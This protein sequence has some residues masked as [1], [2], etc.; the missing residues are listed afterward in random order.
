MRSLVWMIW[1][2]RFDRSTTS[3]SMIPIVPD[4][5]RGEVQRGRRAEPARADQ[6]RLRA[7]QLRLALGADLGD[8]QVA[9]VA[10]LLGLGQLRRRRPVE[11]VR[12]PGLEAARHRRDVG[13][14]HVRERLRGE[15]AADAAGAVQDDGRVAVRDGGLDLLLEVALRDVGGAGDVALVPLGRLA[16]VDHRD[17]PALAERVGLGGRHLADAASSL[18]EKLGVG[19]RHG[20]G[21]APVGRRAAD[22][23]AGRGSGRVRRGMR[24][25]QAG[26]RRD[27]RGRCEPAQAGRRHAQR[28][29]TPSPPRRAAWRRRPRG[30][31]GGSRS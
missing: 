10:L 15:Q 7:Q 25:R 9:A 18:L 11:P 1:R 8:Q 29:I 19:L 3:K 16:D 6:Q 27:A 14:A 28:C 24:V 13:V 2:W 21:G 22:G 23:T 31:A 20:W 12:L 17:G 30:G 4:A 26:R 5:R